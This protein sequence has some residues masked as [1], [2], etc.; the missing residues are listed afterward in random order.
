MWKQLK[1]LIPLSFYILTVSQYRD[2]LKIESY[3]KAWAF[4]GYGALVPHG[5]KF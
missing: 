1:S 4:L 5:Q 2:K 3:G